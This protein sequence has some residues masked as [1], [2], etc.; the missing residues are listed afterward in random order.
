MKLHTE[1][2][3]ILFVDIAGYTTATSR[4]SRT[5]NA[6]LLH[7]FKGT[8]KPIVQRFKGK[9][10]KDIGDAMLLTFSSPTDAML[11]SMAMQ[12]AMHQRNLQ[13]PDDDPIHI[14]VA[15]N[16]GEV[17]VTRNDIFG[18]PVNIAARIEGETPA[19]E[20]YLSEAV[21]MAMNKAEVPAQEVGY[22]NLKGVDQQ[23]KLY[24]IP[25]FATHRLVPQ[26]MNPAEQ[27]SELLFPYGGMHLAEVQE[28]AATRRLLVGGS[29]VAAVLLLVAVALGLWRYYRPQPA[30]LASPTPAPSTAPATTSAT[31]AAPAS[32]PTQTPT[33]AATPPT[34]PVAEQPAPSEQQQAVVPAPQTTVPAPQTAT[35]ETPPAAPEKTPAQSKPRSKAPVAKATP[36]PKPQP[37]LTTISDAKRAYRNGQ[38]SR[39]E[40][41][42][43]AR[44]REETYDERVRQLKLDYRAERISRSEYN[45]RVNALKRQYIGD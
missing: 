17:R 37:R 42:R 39:D 34:P 41:R 33:L 6:D 28:T 32:T 24:S 13:V 26:N 30:A 7:T 16:L 22:F 27:G 15:A 11:C 5:E 19:D 36:K 45:A 31:T 20:I 4:Q 10:I 3:T 8:L 2:L 9:L 12:D 35:L 1:N 29:A 43:I 25:R 23:V 14:R 38:L 18:E 40:Y 44:S 21:F